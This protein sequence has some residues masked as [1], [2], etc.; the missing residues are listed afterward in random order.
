MAQGDGLMPV[1]Q[2]AWATEAALVAA[3]RKVGAQ[4]SEIVEQFTGRDGL[5]RI[6]HTGGSLTVIVPDD[7]PDEN[8]NTGALVDPES[9]VIPTARGGAPIYVP[10]VAEPESADDQ[11]TRLQAELDEAE[12]RVDAP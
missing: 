4:R 3:A 9:P 8:G 12:R 1:D 10:R 6:R 11:R 5:L 7:Q 2:E